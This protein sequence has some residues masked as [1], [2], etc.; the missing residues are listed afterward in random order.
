MDNREISFREK[1]LWL[2]CR[3]R[4]N[5]KLGAEH[6]PKHWRRV[7]VFGDILC[8]L[9]PQADR[10]VVRA[11]AC[12]HDVERVSNLDD[13]EHG[14]RAA[15]L[16]WKLRRTLLSYLNDTQVGL[17]AEA[18]SLHTF[19]LSVPK[20]R[21]GGATVNAC[22]DADRMDLPRAGIIPDPERMAS[23]GGAW[24][25]SGEDFVEAVWE[26]VKRQ[27]DNKKQTRI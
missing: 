16:V 21:L 8:N 2:F 12:L 1:L 19:A 13:N 26:R 23:R 10:M 4:F 24:L 22:F 17:L 9:N 14:Q 18:C 25:V 20:D 6:G 3:M 11:F 7:A 15:F 27:I 5:N